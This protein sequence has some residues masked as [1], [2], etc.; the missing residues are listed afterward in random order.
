VVSWSFSVEG[1]ASARLTRTNPDGSQTALFGGADVDMQGQY[2]DL[3]M[4]P[5]TYTYTLNVSAEFGGTAVK[6]VVVQV[7]SD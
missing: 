6:T 2:E 7:N 4:D 3:M 1:L 5:G